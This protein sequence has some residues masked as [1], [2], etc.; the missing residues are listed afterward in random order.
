MQRPRVSRLRTLYLFVQ[1]ARAALE[2]ASAGETGSGQMEGATVAYAAAQSQYR[3]V[4]RDY[5]EALLRC[6]E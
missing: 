2:A 5:N 6:P 1:E 3:K 4:C